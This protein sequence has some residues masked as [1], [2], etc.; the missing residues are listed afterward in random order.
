MESPADRLIW[1][2]KS[3][4]NGM[5]TTPPILFPPL[6]LATDGSPSAHFA[7]QWLVLLGRSLEP[8]N[9]QNSPALIAA[10]T[11]QPRRSSR[12]NRLLRNLPGG[13]REGEDSHPSAD[14]STTHEGQEK[15]DT[16]LEQ[17]RA[18]FPGDLSIDLQ[19]R[20]G[21]P[22]T[23]V[24]TFART[25]QAGLI[26]VGSRGTGGM[27]ELLLGS[28]SAVV[29]RYA[30]CSVLVARSHP[31]DPP[32]EPKLEHILL[33][34]DDSDGNQVAIA[35]LHQLV[36]IGIRQVTVVYAQ[37]PLNAD[38]LFGPFVA[39]NPSWQ[40]TQS[41][42]EARR[43]QSQQI[44]QE[45]VAAI[46]QPEL[47]V[48]TLLQTGEA[49]P[50]I[51]QVAQQ[52]QV[53]LILMGSSAIRQRR[54]PEPTPPSPEA[55]APAKETSRSPLVSFRKRA[56]GEPR[57]PRPALWNSRLTTTEDYTIHHAPCPVLLCRSV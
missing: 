9:R 22:A 40:L 33:V 26:A 43:E 7:Q 54:H 34:V 5:S 10:V 32:A 44:L 21:R 27:R 38:Y 18:E 53:D 15:T 3:R 55:T 46:R 51:C 47:N 42:Q 16:L 23:E 12:S 39:P 24:L 20:R 13:R 2:Q 29:A 48:Q 41:L 1:W 4:L 35:A 14:A 56:Q 30:P 8:K 11:V 49:G 19:V 28:V 37:P 52:Q 45:A 36:P 31:A 57:A 25:L 6:L 17:I 50:L